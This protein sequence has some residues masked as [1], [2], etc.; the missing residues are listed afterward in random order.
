VD[1]LIGLV[2]VAVKS[3]VK[4]LY[5]ALDGSQSVDTSIKQAKIIEFLLNLRNDKDTVIQIMQREENLGSGAGVINAINWFFSKEEAGIILEDDLVVESNF[6]SYMNQVISLIDSD[7]S[8]LLASGTRLR[9]IK[10][11]TSSI[12]S[13]PVV[14]GWA[15]SRNKWKVMSTLIFQD[16]NRYESKLSLSERVFWRTGKRRALRSQIDAWDI[17]L[18]AGMR[19]K[20]YLS[21]VP[22]INLV[23]NIGFDNVASHTTTPNWPLQLKLDP[24]LPPQIEIDRSCSELSANDELMRRRIFRITTKNILTGVISIWL[25][26]V[27]FYGRRKKLNLV[28]RAN[29]M[30]GITL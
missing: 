22:P 23:S 28:D 8:I 10:S 6:F 4:S 25:D 3:N 29:R 7:P 26:P 27:R 2:E 17:P 20:G 5:V 13:Y 30:F 1:S 15:T 18:S 21:L 14:W 16:D 9:D 24:E 12:C 11:Q 19:E